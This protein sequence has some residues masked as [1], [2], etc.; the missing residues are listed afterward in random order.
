MS[1]DMNDDIQQA[2]EELRHQQE[3][4]RA[5]R[6]KVRET[7]IKVRSPDGLITVTLDGQGEVSS[8]AFNSAKFRRMAPAELGAALVQAIKRARTESRQ[9]MFRAYSP[10][11]PKGM[12]L[13]AD[14][15][16][17]AD[18]DRLFDDAVSKASEIM[19]DGQAG[20]DVP[21]PSGH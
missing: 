6:A 21:R 15:D 20:L 5:L 9:Q 17:T 12:D 10:F 4:L 7:Q 11:L 18:L 13:F 14:R 16:G 1:Y 19:I 3:L 8:I 2:T